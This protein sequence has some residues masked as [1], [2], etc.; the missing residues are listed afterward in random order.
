MITA[1]VLIRAAKDTIPET[2]QTIADIEG[3]AEVY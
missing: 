3:V 2:A 1:I